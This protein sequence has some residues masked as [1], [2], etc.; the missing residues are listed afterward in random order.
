MLPGKQATFARR[1]GRQ[2]S[3]GTVRRVLAE[4][5]ELGIVERVDGTWQRCQELPEMATRSSVGG[6]E[7]RDA[8]A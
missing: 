3:D 5:A 1:L 7:Q 2:K 4:L 6:D 8:A